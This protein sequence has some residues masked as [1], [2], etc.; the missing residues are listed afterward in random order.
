MLEELNVDELLVEDDVVEVVLVAVTLLLGFA[1][2]V[3]VVED[4]PVP[5]VLFA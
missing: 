4:E 5:P 3:L 1:E 2:E